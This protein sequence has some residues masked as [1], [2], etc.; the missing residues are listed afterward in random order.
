[1]DIEPFLIA[2]SVE[3]IVAQRLVRRL[4]PNCAQPAQ[5]DPLYIESCLATMHI[6]PEEAR[7]GNLAKNAHGCERC[8]SLGFRGRIGI[9]EILRVT[10]EIH[11]HIVQRASA[12][13]IRQTAIEQGMNTLMRSGWAHIK[14]GHTTLEEVMRYAEIENEENNPSE[15]LH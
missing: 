15:I 5:H 7:F 6:P 8:R 9:F 2:S 3:M 10:D 12:R 1:M 4:C 14:S 11:E 13:K